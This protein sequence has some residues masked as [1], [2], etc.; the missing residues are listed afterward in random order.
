MIRDKEETYSSE[1]HCEIRK[2][3]MFD[4]LFLIY[5]L[6]R[7]SVYHFVHV[8]HTR[9]HTKHDEIGDKDK[10]GNPIESAQK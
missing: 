10:S 6:W 8:F 4:P 9:K 5:C 7:Y 3:L 2:P 1:W